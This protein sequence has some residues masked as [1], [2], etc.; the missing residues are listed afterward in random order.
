[1][2]SSENTSKASKVRKVRK[3]SKTSKTS[4]ASKVRKNIDTLLAKAHAAYHTPPTGP[5]STTCKP[6]DVFALPF[7]STLLYTRYRPKP[8]VPV[9]ISHR[10]GVSSAVR[11][12]DADRAV[13]RRPARVGHSVDTIQAA[14]SPPNGRDASVPV[15]PHGVAS[16]TNLAFGRQ[17]S[18]MPVSVN[19]I[20]SVTATPTSQRSL[21]IP[22]AQQVPHDA[23]GGPL[24]T[25]AAAAGSLASA[26]PEDI[27]AACRKIKSCKKKPE[28][29]PMRSEL[30]KAMPE[31]FYA[32]THHLK[33][34]SSLRQYFGNER[35]LTKEEW[36]YI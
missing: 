12:N 5:P 21:S 34:H 13:W 7:D 23:I 22:V 11:V 26:I 16:K 27:V 30:H 36:A 9:W 31:H 6:Q 24:P 1:M 35:L 18:I 4:Q 8:S 20:A 32:Q 29:M 15:F 3:T 28:G 19:N 10:A 14:A 33:R 25:A 17:V 2:A